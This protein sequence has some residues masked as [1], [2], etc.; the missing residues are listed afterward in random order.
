MENPSTQRKICPRSTLPPLN[1]T[2][3][4]LGLNPGLLAKY[5]RVIAWA[6][7]RKW[8]QI[9]VLRDGVEEI[10][11][12][13]K[14]WEPCRRKWLIFLQS[15]WERCG[16][17]CFATAW[18]ANFHLLWIVV[19]LYI[20][21]MSSYMLQGHLLSRKEGGCRNIPSNIFTCYYTKETS[22]GDLYSP[23]KGPETPFR[24]SR[25]VLDVTY[26][27]LSLSE[28]PIG[29]RSHSPHS[30]WRRGQMQSPK[31][32]EVFSLKR[33]AMSKI[34]VTSVTVQCR[35]IS[36]HSN[37]RKFCFHLIILS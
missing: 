6:K 3:T 24:I 23:W 36:L 37:S 13:T 15:G 17:W 20:A 11:A 25:N 21:P 35:Q 32:S 9:N 4:G 16:E 18:E 34:S 22:A 19:S 8:R 30:T 14:P 5:R 1:L 31:L 10:Y 12:K 28:G 26:F 33:L 27:G 7:A 2:W 29:V